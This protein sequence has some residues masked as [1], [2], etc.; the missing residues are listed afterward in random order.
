MRLIG[1]WRT[2]L[3]RSSAMWAQY[4]QGLFGLLAIV[5]PGAALGVWRMLPDSFASRVPQAFV[6]RVGQVLFVLALVTIA[7][8]IVHQP[9]LQEKRDGG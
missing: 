2:V 3:K 6:E 5:D 9:K 4:L 1:G 8:R 7:A